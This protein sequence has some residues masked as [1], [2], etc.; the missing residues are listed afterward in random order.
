MEGPESLLPAQPGQKFVGVLNRK[1]AKAT[2]A[3]ELQHPRDHE[4]AQ[5]AVGVVE[6]PGLLSRGAA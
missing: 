1:R 6:K 3:I 4:L 5:P 2:A